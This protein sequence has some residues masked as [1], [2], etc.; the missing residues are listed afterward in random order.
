MGSRAA[1]RFFQITW[2]V[3]AV[4][5]ILFFCY[6]ML[7]LSLPYTSFEKD[8]DFLRTK[9][10]VYHIDYWRA[11]F[12]AHVFSSVL[13]LLAGA[14]QFSGTLIRRYPKVHRRLGI[15][16]VIIVLFISGPGAFAM[17]LH[18]NG[19][20]PAKAS[21]VLQ[22]ALWLCFTA[23]A[24]YF[25]VKKKFEIHGEFMLRSYALT[26]A[27]ISLRLLVLFFT[28]VKFRGVRPVEVYI[29]VAWLSW[30]PNLILA[31][32]MIRMGVIRRILKRR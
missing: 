31:E 29:T 22:T 16:Y 17:S 6:R 32:V 18:A 2:R 12:Y 5:G 23:L 11:G 7:L 21:F 1:N 3:L 4:A 9:Y 15:G 20:L 26:F 28:T 14:T 30:V 27:A 8:V 24:F 25:A 19:G 13:V 10:N